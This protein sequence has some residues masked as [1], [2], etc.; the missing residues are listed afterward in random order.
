[1]EI[2]L[3]MK[4]GGSTPASMQAFSDKNLFCQNRN[5]HQVAKLFKDHA[6]AV[7]ARGLGNILDDDENVEEKAEYRNVQWALTIKRVNVVPYTLAEALATG[8]VAGNPNPPPATDGDFKRKSR[9]DDLLHKQTR[10]QEQ[11]ITMLWNMMDTITTQVNLEF[12]KANNAITFREKLDNMEALLLELAEPQ[13]DSTRTTYLDFFRKQPRVS[14]I[15]AVNLMCA[16]FSYAQGELAKLGLNQAYPRE[17]HI[18]F[19]YDNLKHPRDFKEAKIWYKA[20]KVNNIIGTA[21][22][23]L[24]QIRNCFPDDESHTTISPDEI[25]TEFE[26]D[27]HKED[28]DHNNNK[29]KIKDVKA[30]ARMD[31]TVSADVNKGNSQ[32]FT[33]IQEFTQQEVQRQMAVERQRN[34]TGRGGSAGYGYYSAVQSKAYDSDGGYQSSPGGGYVSSNGTR[35]SNRNE[36]RT[37]QRGMGRGRSYGDGGRGGGNDQRRRSP[38]P[39]HGTTSYVTDGEGYRYKLQRIDDTKI[40]SSPSSPSR[41]GFPKADGKK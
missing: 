35:Y 19:I 16:R 28:S 40:P 30:A 33:N 7:S 25:I 23:F 41:S 18:R 31:I 24:V 11:V 4:K 29:D 36:R 26:I 27:H 34:F 22:N 21:N 39:M 9:Y 38:S 37:F 14:D 17:E 6:N 8:M 32:M 1:L 2:I 12:I 15:R 3:K 5:L 10:G 13:Q 20:N